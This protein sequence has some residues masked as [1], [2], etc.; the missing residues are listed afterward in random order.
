M[1]DLSVSADHIK[2]FRLA[3]QLHR[4]RIGYGAGNLTGWHRTPIRGVLRHYEQRAGL[5]RE[6]DVESMLMHDDAANIE[7]R[8]HVG[9]ALV[10]L[11]E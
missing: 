2:V 7:A 4:I 9:I 8:V 1:P 6:S 10:D 3:M 11:V 5:R